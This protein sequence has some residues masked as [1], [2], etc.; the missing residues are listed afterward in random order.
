MKKAKAWLEKRSIGYETR[1]IVNDPL[2]ASELR[3]LHQKSG[4]DRKRFVNTSGKRYRELGL[5]DRLDAF[6]DDQLF[7]LLA[8]DGLLV[9]RPVLTDG[10]TV[11]AGFKE[12]EWEAVFRNE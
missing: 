8:T 12:E 1:H 10:T 2:T 3:E 5:K 9:R 6:S 11:L 7:A 4:L